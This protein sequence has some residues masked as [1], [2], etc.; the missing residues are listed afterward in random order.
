ME[1]V[2]AGLA[3]AETRGIVHRDL[4]PEN[5]LVT[6]DGRVKIAD[7][8]IAKATQSAGTGAFLTATGHDRRHADVHG[9][10]AGDGPGR[11]RRGPTSTRSA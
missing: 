2:L 10:R 5:L 11:R 7:F 3:H 4:K 9:A 8:G 6:A 1:G